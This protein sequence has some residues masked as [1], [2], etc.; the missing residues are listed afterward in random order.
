MSWATGMS[1]ILTP[2]CPVCGQPPVMVFGGWTQAFC[3]NDDCNIVCWDPSKS[4]DD[5][6]LDVGF[7][8]LTPDGGEEEKD[9]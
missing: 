4:L 8:T 5:N 7:V 6:L 3:G 9:G 2:D 1:E